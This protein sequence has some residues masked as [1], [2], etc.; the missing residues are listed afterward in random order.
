[1]VIVS[2]L[3]PTVSPD[4]VSTIISHID[5]V[6]NFPHLG[7]VF[8]VLDS[9]DLVVTTLDLFTSIP[10]LDLVATLP[11]PVLVSLYLGITLEL[12]PPG[13]ELLGRF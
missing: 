9:L 5:L 1:M 3:D 12:P 11:H 7:L 4:F 6:T 10:I 13:H 8:S 2:Y